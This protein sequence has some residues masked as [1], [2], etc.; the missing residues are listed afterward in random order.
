MKPADNS[1]SCTPSAAARLARGLAPALM[2]LAVSLPTYAATPKPAD[3][4]PPPPY[5][6][7]GEIVAASPAEAWRAPDPE[8]IIYMDLPTGRVVIELAPHMAPATVANIRTLIREKYFDGMAIVRSQDNYVVQWGDPVDK[9]PPKPL[10]SAKATLSPEWQR[11]M[12]PA[13]WKS[14]GFVPLPDRDGYAKEVGFWRGFHAGRD[15]ASRTAWLSHC[16]GTVGVG[17]GSAADSGSGASLYVVTGHAP[18]HL[19][20][21]ITVVG[22][23][24]QGMP[25]LSVL[26]RGTKPLGFYATPEEML[27]LK[28][29]RLEADVPA[30]DRTAMEVFRTESPEF[31]R[32][33]EALRNRGGD[34]FKRPAGHVE[35]CNVP[36]PARATRVER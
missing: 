10:G 18:R 16:Y 26:P 11:S 7:F 15:A 22:R 20:R 1:F 30:A 13:E 3:K 5:K 25:L 23:V 9:T 6:S 8:N 17:R 21:N 29:F 28:S 32:G 34:W 33:V 36:I 35:L 2:V 24:L 12:T 4:T 27:P 19:D 14:M 31:K